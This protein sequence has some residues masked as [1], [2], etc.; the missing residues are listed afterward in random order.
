[1]MS[2]V[3]LLN[4]CFHVVIYPRR[5]PMVKHF[6]FMEDTIGYDIKNSLKIFVFKAWSEKAVS[7]LNWDMDRWVR[8]LFAS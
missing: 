5:L 1:M 7:Q 3:F 6:G 8:S 4:H 2:F